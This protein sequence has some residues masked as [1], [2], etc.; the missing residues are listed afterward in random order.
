MRGWQ[1]CFCII[2]SDFDAMQNA[3]MAHRNTIVDQYEK[4]HGWPSEYSRD[5]LHIPGHFHACSYWLW[6]R[7]VRKPRQGGSWHPSH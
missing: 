3:M 6:K 5:E 1:H 7:N 2:T 4:A